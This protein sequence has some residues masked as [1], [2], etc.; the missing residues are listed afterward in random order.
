MIK[1]S[2]TPLVF[3]MYIYSTYYSCYNT[4]MSTRVL[5]LNDTPWAQISNEV[6]TRHNLPLYI[7]LGQ[8]PVKRDNPIKKEFPGATNLYLTTASGQRIAIVGVLP[9]SK[10]NSVWWRRLLG[11]RFD[12]HDTVEACA[13]RNKEKGAA[14]WVYEER[15]NGYG[16]TFV[17]IHALD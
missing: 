3:I 13:K 17:T 2:T 6:Q 5:S 16:E 12:P 15:I 10:Q 1:T 11:M 9:T 4:F 7:K 14:A 8:E